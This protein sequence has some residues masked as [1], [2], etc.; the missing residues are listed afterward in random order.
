MTF[1]HEKYLMNYNKIII[2]NYLIT[3]FTLLKF[4]S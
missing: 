3:F 2:Q 1:I 4:T